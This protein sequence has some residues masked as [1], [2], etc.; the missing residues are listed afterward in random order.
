MGRLL[1]PGISAQ[2]EAEAGRLQ[3]QPAPSTFYLRWRDPSRIRA[4]ARTRVR[5]TRADTAR[6]PRRGSRAARARNRLELRLGHHE[7]N[8]PHHEPLESEADGMERVRS[9]LQRMRLGIR[10]RSRCWPVCHVAPATPR[11]APG[12][13]D[14]APG[15]TRHRARIPPQNHRTDTARPW[16]WPGRIGEFALRLCSSTGPASARRDV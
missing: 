8:R 16:Q 5:V 6:S 15:S 10:W 1:A 3:G 9:E 14:I 11:S 12:T 4:T 13:T 7:V 2:T